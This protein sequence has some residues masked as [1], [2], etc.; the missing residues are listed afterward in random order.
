MMMIQMMIT[1][2][3]QMMMSDDDVDDEEYG[4]DSERKNF[5][6]PGEFMSLINSYIDEGE[7]RRRDRGRGI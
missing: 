6:M 5:R 2:M 4:W 7:Q 3:I 1:M